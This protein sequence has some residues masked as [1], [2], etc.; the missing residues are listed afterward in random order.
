MVV[1]VDPSECHPQRAI[2]QFCIELLE[3]RE[4]KLDAATTRNQGSFCCSGWCICLGTMISLTGSRLALSVSRRLPA[5]FFVTKTSAGIGV[6]IR[7]G[8][9][10]NYRLRTAIARTQPMCSATVNLPYRWPVRSRKLD[11]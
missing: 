7:Q 5:S 4:E 8:I 2:T 9:G 6:A 11:T 1:I 3:A 10:S